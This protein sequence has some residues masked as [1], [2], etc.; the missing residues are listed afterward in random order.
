MKRLIAWVYGKGFD[1]WT[2]VSFMVLGI[3]GAI[4]IIVMGV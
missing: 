2:H 1:F 3:I 4:I